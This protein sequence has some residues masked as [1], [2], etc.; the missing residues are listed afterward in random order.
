MAARRYNAAREGRTMHVRCPHCQNAIEI[1]GDSDIHDVTCPS[2]GSAF[3]LVPKTEAYHA[4]KRAIAHFEL[5][6]P[7]GAGGFGTVFKARDTKLDRLV[8]IKIPRSDQI[9]PQNVE[10]FLREAR[11]AAQLRHPNI[12]AVH[13]VG[14]ENDTLYIVSDFIAGVTLADR[15]TAGPFT[16]RDAAQL[17]AQIAQALHHAH[18]AGVIHR[19]LK[20]QNIMLDAAGQPHLM[21]FGLAKREAGEVT[22]T[23]DGKILGTPAYMSPEQARGEGHRADR[24]TDIYSLGVILFQSLTGELPFR[25]N[26]AMLLHQ[27]LHDEPPSPRKLNGARSAG[28]GDHHAQVFGEGLTTPLCDRGRRCDRIAKALGRAAHSRPANLIHRAPGDGPSGM[29][30]SPAYWPLCWWDWSPVWRR[31][32]A[33]ALAFVVMLCLSK[34]RTRRLSSRIPI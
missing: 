30:P 34:K 16:P 4:T 18:D 25:G 14:R 1:I 23:F 20:P 33:S 10:T 28:F 6:E 9:E 29:S 26:R 22:M 21:D 11:A 7:L 2:C 5:I 12:V 32:S 27:V 13:E 24:R 15:L 3:D 17:L 19:D 31:R 8:A